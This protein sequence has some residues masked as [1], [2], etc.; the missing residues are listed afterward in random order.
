[1]VE[2]DRQLGRDAGLPIVPLGTAGSVASAPSTALR[3]AA[4][5]SMSASGFME[6]S[7]ALFTI[8][9]NHEFDAAIN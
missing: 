7:V 3:A 6:P 8:N 2:A 1:M 9:I 5:V 4:V